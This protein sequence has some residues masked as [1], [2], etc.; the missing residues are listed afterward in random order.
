MKDFGYDISDFIDIDPLFGTMDDFR[1]L[2]AI[3]HDFGKSHFHA[4]PCKHYRK[5]FLGL[6]VVL[7][8]VPN[9]SS[10]EHEWFLQSVNREDPYTEYYVWA[11]PKAYGEDGSP[12]PPNNWVSQF[13]HSAWEYMEERQQFYLHQFD[14]GQPDLNFRNPVV[15]QE[16]MD[17]LLY[18]LGNGADGFRMDAVS[19]SVGQPKQLSRLF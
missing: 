13:G 15:V 5:L 3:A 8:Y 14:V 10:D 16:M 4:Y 6:K 2:T 18:W 7:D 12:I 11:D 1:E 9:H 17:V 19:Y